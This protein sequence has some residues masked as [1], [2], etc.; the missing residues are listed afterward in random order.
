M[1]TSEIS[2][3]NISGAGGRWRTADDRED[4]PPSPGD[5]GSDGGGSGDDD[6]DDEEEEEEEETDDNNDEGVDPPPNP[7][8]LQPCTICQRPNAR[9]RLD[10]THRWRPWAGSLASMAMQEVHAC[11]DCIR[12]NDWWPCAHQCSRCGNGLVNYALYGREYSGFIFW[13]P[14]PPQRCCMRAGHVERQWPRHCCSSCRDIL[15][16]QFWH[17]EMQ[18]NIDYE[19]GGGD[20]GAGADAEASTPQQPSSSSNQPPPADQALEDRRQYWDGVLRSLGEN[21][22][23]DN[24]DGEDDFSCEELCMGCAVADEEQRCEVR[25]CCLRRGGHDVHVC[26]ACLAPVDEPGDEDNDEDPGD[27]Q[28]DE[29]DDED[30]DHPD[31]TFDMFSRGSRSRSPLRILDRQTGAAAAA[32]DGANGG[33]KAKGR[34]HVEA[35]AEGLAAPSDH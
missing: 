34:G 8:C 6:D 18:Q 26:R 16:D 29:D 11:W 32:A 7:P 4:E 17:D 14:Y 28:D 35:Q 20:H 27:D 3:A 22:V 2:N 19:L 33:A 23:A 13:Y 15:V 25:R 12:S 31:H 10:A 24:L 21:A 1:I 5:F 30:P 9:C